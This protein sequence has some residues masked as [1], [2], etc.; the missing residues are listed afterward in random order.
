MLY[1]ICSYC[2]CAL[3]GSIADDRFGSYLV[4]PKVAFM[5][6]ILNNKRLK[7]D[8]VVIQ[9]INH[10]IVFLEILKA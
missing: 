4:H 5:F 9:R 8:F 7:P 2:L 10:C 1:F 3:Q 6:N